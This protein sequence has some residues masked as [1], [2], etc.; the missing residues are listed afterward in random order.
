MLFIQ[1]ILHSNILQPR[2]RDDLL[3][4]FITVLY[5]FLKQFLKEIGQLFR[6]VYVVWKLQIIVNY[7]GK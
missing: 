6:Q 7:I 1:N 3:I 2:I 4:S 5:L